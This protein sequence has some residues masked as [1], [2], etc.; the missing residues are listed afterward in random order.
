MAAQ[1]LGYKPR[2]II[3]SGPSG[4]GKGSV[5]RIL[6][7]YP[8]LKLKFSV[9]MTTRPPRKGEVHKK[10]YF[11]VSPQQFQKAV[12]NH[13]LIENATFVGN[14]YGT[15]RKYVEEQLKRGNNVILEIEVDGAT[16]ALN[17]EKDTLSIFLMPPNL[18]EL[19]SR[20]QG[21]R[22]ESSEL[23]KQRLDK[24]LLEIP[25]KHSYQYVVENDSIENA[26]AK[27]IDIL[28]KE[29]AVPNHQ[30][31]VYKKLQKM[32]TEIVRANYR[33]FVDNWEA[34][35]QNLKDSG[36]ITSEDYN[37]FDAETK[38]I[39]TLTNRVYHRNLA[40]GI[41]A[42]LEDY[43]YVWGQIQRLMFKI[44]FFSIVQKYE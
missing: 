35:I 17:N 18:Q 37:K 20:L 28:K 26:A 39:T 38:L 15:P 9:S 24:A 33:F 11:F 22:S 30:H 19:A 14:R 21:R 12:L 6:Q 3:V 27:I 4:V 40:H 29:K 34:N 42:D 25:L 31:T 8:D 16:Q 13:E 36:L 41:F 7:S 44:N 10:D 32:V 2:M 5:N 1:K 23:I 43:D